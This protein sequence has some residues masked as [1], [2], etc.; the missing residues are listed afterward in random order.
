M[1]SQAHVMMITAVASK[2][3]VL[4]HPIGSNPPALHIQLL[5]YAIPSP[6]PPPPLSVTIKPPRL[7]LPPPPHAAAH[8]IDLTVAEHQL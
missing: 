4:K 2:I 6:P 5:E 1:P 8:S 3:T 7:P